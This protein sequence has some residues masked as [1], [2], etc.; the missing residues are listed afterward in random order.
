MNDYSS[1][2]HI[3]IMPFYDLILTKSMGLRTLRTP[4]SRTLHVDQ[5]AGWEKV[6]KKM[7]IGRVFQG[8]FHVEE[9][10]DFS[11]ES[12]PGTQRFDLGLHTPSTL[13]SFPSH[14]ILGLNQLSPL[15]GPSKH[16]SPWSFSK[17]TLPAIPGNCCLIPLCLWVLVKLCLVATDISISSPF[18]IPLVQFKWP[19]KSIDQSFMGQSIHLFIPTPKKVQFWYL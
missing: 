18:D 6:K 2:I 14:E 9:T 11:L 12:P 17:A 7:L 1:G 19:L 13:P 8:L 4:S 5:Y 15:P 10:S 16:I 3:R